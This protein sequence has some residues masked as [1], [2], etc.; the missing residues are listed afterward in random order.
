MDHALTSKL[1]NFEIVTPSL[2]V[3]FLEQGCYPPLEAN[4]I[5]ARVSRIEVI[6]AGGG[7]EL[8]RE[9]H[10]SVLCLA[11]E[12]FHFAVVEAMD[13]AG[14][15]RRVEQHAFDAPHRRQTLAEP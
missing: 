1:T 14:I 4:A 2:F 13:A 10:A 15:A 6:F 11:G 7:T 12:R 5:S 8:L 3:D 9:L